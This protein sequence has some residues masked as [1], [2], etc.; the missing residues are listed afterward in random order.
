M[1]YRRRHIHPKIK[2]IK[3][4]KLFLRPIFWIALLSLIIVVTSA[5]FVLFS[6]SFQVTEIEISGNE[7]VESGNIKDFLSLE[8]SNRI[9]LIDKNKLKSKVLHKFPGIESL[10]IQKRFSHTIAL[11]IKERVPFAIFCKKDGKC[12]LI[13]ENGVVFEETQ[14]ITQDKIILS[15]ENSE[16]V[17]LGETVILKDII[18]S[19]SKIND[20]LKDNFQISTKEVLVSSF[21]IFKTSENWQ[22]YFDPTSDIDLQITK[23][24][25]LLENEISVTERKNL[26]Y[27]YLQYKDRAYYK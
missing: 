9:L 7:K 16:N 8:M 12:F 2:K 19:I 3:S 10:T 25:S 11:N 1:S 18:S 24:N 5:Y 21:L 20:N 13:D 17:F 26:Q 23:M 14:S 22:I 27:I 15:K 6:P 4:K